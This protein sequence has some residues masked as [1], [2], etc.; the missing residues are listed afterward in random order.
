MI[1]PVAM[2][3]IFLLLF[4]WVAKADWSP[5]IRLID[6]TSIEGTGCCNLRIYCDA[7]RG[8]IVYLSRSFG[9]TSPGVAVIHQ[10]EMCK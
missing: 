4:V 9:T 1:R 7:P 6:Q 5:T 10:P 3:V 2:V 8:N